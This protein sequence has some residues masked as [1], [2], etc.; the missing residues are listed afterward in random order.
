MV[1]G[2]RAVVSCRELWLPTVLVLL[3][4]WA[5]AAQASERV[6]FRVVN[7]HFQDVIDDYGLDLS[8]DVRE[9]A[10]HIA[11]VGSDSQTGAQLL[12]TLQSD[13]RVLN[14]ETAFVAAISEYQARVNLGSDPGDITSELLITGLADD[15]CVLD[16]PPEAPWA[17]W[18]DQGAAEIIG[19]GFAQDE[20]W[21]CGEILVAVIDTGVDPRHP[22]L[23]NALVE[24][25]DFLLDSAGDGSEWE[26]LGEDAATVEQSIT[27]LVEQSI[28]AL[29][30][31]N[32]GALV[33]EQSITALVEQ[34]ITD[35]VPPGTTLPP[36]FGHGTMVAGII[37]LMAPAA[38]IMPLRAFDG[39]GRGRLIDIV[40]AIRF[41][42]DAGA[43]VINLSFSIELDSP[44]L[45]D[46]IYYAHERGA[47]MVAAVGNRG[48]EREAYPAAFGRVTGVG[49]TND[50][51]EPSSFSSYGDDL[52]DIVAPGEGIIT[53]YPG[54]LYA[55][56]W[57][58]SF[59][60]PIVSGGVGLLLG[61]R[62]VSP[63]LDGET[64]VD[65]IEHAAVELPYSEDQV[66]RGRFDLAQAWDELDEMLLSTLIF[67]DGIED[68][69]GEWSFIEGDTD[70][71]YEEDDFED[72]DE[73][74]SWDCEEDDDRWGECHEH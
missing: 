67:V 62:P 3:L 18:T 6:V 41:A 45:E 61:E 46:A 5:T 20:S 14:A 72:D 51:D 50:L 43:D 36:A 66:G 11:D 47:V 52:V 56:G 64:V 13:P 29:V 25:Y 54:G 33:L 69:L 12:A 9:G 26:A 53:A 15:E 59:S 24:G 22:L 19:L 49:S 37:R 40:D 23:A 21:L 35:L 30:E 17:G 60:A 57:G 65:A 44:E 27:A 73:P 71:L 2:R 42:A 10:F 63:G 32:G 7:T 16:G 58:T 55:A 48:D 31:G 34:S 4:V 68:G 74:D 38:Q 28:T 8:E 39:N 70:D 1:A